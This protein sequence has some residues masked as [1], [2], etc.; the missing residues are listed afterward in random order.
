MWI[1]DIL[2]KVITNLITI[3]VVGGVIYFL[4]RKFI[5]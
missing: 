1:G 3:A 4:V 5:F 2:K